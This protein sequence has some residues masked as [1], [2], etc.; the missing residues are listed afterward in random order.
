MNCKKCKNYEA[1]VESK[2]SKTT[3]EVLSPTTGDKVLHKLYISD[4]EIWLDNL[5]FEYK[6]RTFNLTYFGNVEDFDVPNDIIKL[7]AQEEIEFL[8]FED[9]KD[10]NKK[11]VFIYNY[12]NIDRSKKISDFMEKS[13][14]DLS[15]RLISFFEYVNKD[16]IN[17]L[18]AIAGILDIYNN[19]EIHH[20]DTMNAAIN[21][22]AK[23]EIEN[24]NDLED[25]THR[26]SNW[27]NAADFDILDIP[28]IYNVDID[29][30]DV[31]YPKY[32]LEELVVFLGENNFNEIEELV[33][34]FE[35]IK[36]YN[37]L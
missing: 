25:Y 33:E 22:I 29:T 37:K 4:T 9:L 30:I 6:G 24:I 3:I 16:N 8:C 1:I 26:F 17:Y 34:L 7:Y 12:N 2:M 32:V 23:N 31:V 20:F 28:I 18:A 27:S 10:F 14:C 13:K 35:D 15:K 5:K 21:N 11:D 36:F 19:E